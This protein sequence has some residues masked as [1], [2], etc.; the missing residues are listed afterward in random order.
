MYR[1]YCAC[2]V[3]GELWV[4]AELTEPP[5]RAWYPPPLR[6]PLSDQIDLSCRHNLE[7]YR[8]VKCAH[9]KVLG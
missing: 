3:P 4:H 8:S 6:E 5:V 2:K 1:A 7:W 9:V